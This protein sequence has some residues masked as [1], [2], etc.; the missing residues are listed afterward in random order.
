VNEAYRR[1][2]ASSRVSRGT[3]AALEGRET[4]VAGGEPPAALDAVEL[5]MLSILIDC[6]IPQAEGLQIDLTSQLHATLAGGSGDGWRFAS[7]PPDLPAYRA[8]LRTLDAV[9][10]QRFDASW[11]QSLQQQREQL[12]ADTVAGRV[13]LTQP[14]SPDNLDAAQL[15]AWFE[16]VRA[17]AVRLYVAHP[18][19]LARLG[20]SGIAN[21]GDGMPKSGFEQVGLGERESWEPGSPPARTL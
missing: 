6:V 14:R 9:A 17:D 2:L 12:L 8:G 20:Y 13:H 5:G 10:R 15:Q 11:M 21:G 16:D 7:L 3:R 1:L 18:Q 19:T 4:P